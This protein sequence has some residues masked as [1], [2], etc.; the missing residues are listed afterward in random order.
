MGDALDLLRNPPCLWSRE[1][2]LDRPCPVPSVPGVY[3]WFF[4]EVP[5]G[6]PAADCVVQNHLN[7]LTLLYVGIA[8]KAPSQVGRVSSATLRS[9]IRQHYRGNA[10]GS[11]LRLTLGCLLAEQL[12]IELC[13]VGTK[14]RLTFAAGEQRLSEWMDRNAFVCWVEHPRPWEVEPGI[15]AELRPPLNLR[16]NRT[17]P[18]HVTLRSAARDETQSATHM[19]TTAWV[20]RRFR[21]GSPNEI[22]GRHGGQH[23]IMK[24]WLRRS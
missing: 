12:G 18:F 23:A 5:P 2:V 20:S 16:E 9:R 11:T 15:I 4:R 6:V 10:S 24:S 22:D 8:P 21:R 1:E 13:N 3:A 17:H 14:E 7:H 19:I